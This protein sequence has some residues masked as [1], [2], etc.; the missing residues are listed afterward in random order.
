[1]GT[2]DPSR[3]AGFSNIENYS[4]T[5]KDRRTLRGYKL[6][7]SSPL[8]AV[9]GYLLLAQGNAMLADQ[10]AAEFLP[11]TSAGYD[12]YLFDYRGYGQSDGKARLKAIL[13]DYSEIITHLDSS[14]YSNRLFYGLSFG[15][16]IL[17]DALKD[18]S[19]ENRLVIDSTPSRFSI[20]GCPLAHDPV[21]NLPE[22][23]S[24]ALII[25]G[26]RD[27]VVTSEMSKE[28]VD[29]AQNRGASLLRDADLAHPFMDVDSLLHNRRMQAVRTFLLDE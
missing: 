23:S 27:K 16:M 10:I 3:L 17:L 5:T 25:V 2:P 15:G 29:T 9:K 6:H 22:N 20:Y 26:G 18:K 11:F 13:S 28:L 4:I 21:E 14:A 7:A 12:V 8:G 1:A 19:G 24:N